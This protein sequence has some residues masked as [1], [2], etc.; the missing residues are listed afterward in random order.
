MRHNQEIF[1]IH[2]CRKIYDR[3]NN[4][5]SFNISYETH[6]ELTS[7]TIIVA[8]AFGLGIDEAQRFPVLEAELKIRPNDVVFIT[9]DSG[10][11]K[12]VLL[13]AIK[14]DLGDEAMDLAEVVV[15]ESKPLI[16]LI[17]STI[18]EALEPLSSVGLNDAFLFFEKV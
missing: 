18:E 2:A 13:R 7:R 15:D 14:A 17:G 3:Q 5:F 10:S 12:S 1:R 9:G 4:R 8:D 16:E 11:G 6:A